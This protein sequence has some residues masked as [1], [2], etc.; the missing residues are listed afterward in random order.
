MLL[1][2]LASSQYQRGDFDSGRR[3]LEEAAG[4]Q[5]KVL[6]AHHPDLA[7]TLNNLAHVHVLAG[8]PQLALPHQQEA[9]DIWRSAHGP[10][11]PYVMRAMANLGKMHFQLDEFDMAEE[12]TRRALEMMR[13]HV[14]DDPMVGDLEE[15]LEQI[16]IRK[17]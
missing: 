15:R 6:G 2:N 11:H 8:E 17:S 7:I 14:P 5:R 1:V 16:L 9:L 13:I 10:E 3:L 12:W 4:L